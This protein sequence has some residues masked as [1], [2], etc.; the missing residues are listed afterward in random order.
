VCESLRLSCIT[1]LY[2]TFDACALPYFRPPGGV[3]TMTFRDVI[4]GLYARS[5]GNGSAMINR[6]PFA[7]ED[8][9][10]V[11]RYRTIHRWLASLKLAERYI[12]LCDQDKK[13]S[14]TVKDFIDNLPS[15]ALFSSISPDCPACTH[16]GD[17]TSMRKEC[18]YIF[19]T[20]YDFRCR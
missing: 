12:I 9:H 13:L 8:L 7:N 20:G 10:L 16:C 1:E 4:Y 3:V 2:V 14:K 18:F 19:L 5:V 6:I 15:T 11:Q 17:F